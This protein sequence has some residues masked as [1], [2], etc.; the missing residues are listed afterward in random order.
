MN[1]YDLFSVQRD[2][3]KL[4]SLYIEL[5][6]HEN[7]NPYKNNV[8]TDMPNGNKGINFLEWYAEEKER[9]E[10]EIKLYKEKAQ[11]DRKMLDEIIKEAPYP[12]SDLIQYKVINNL[13]WTEIGD[14]IPMDRSLASKKFKAYIKKIPTFPTCDLI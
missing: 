8:I 13:S 9:I 14:M 2:T 11:W 3:N 4:K 7:F 10:K 1:L 12:E 6:N 5:A